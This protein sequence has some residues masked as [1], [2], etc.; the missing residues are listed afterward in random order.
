MLAFSLPSLQPHGAPPVDANKVEAAYDDA[1]EAISGLL[2]L[3]LEY[4]LDRFIP[5]KLLGKVLTLA[6]GEILNIQPEIQNIN[7]LTLK[8]HKSN[9][10]CILFSNNKS[11]KGCG[12]VKTYRY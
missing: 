9:G 1:V 8:Y 12:D 10:K 11:Y 6:D 7:E 4:T 5:Y 2:T 3:R